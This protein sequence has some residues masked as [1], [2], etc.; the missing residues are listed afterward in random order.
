MK[1]N[2]SQSN[3]KSEDTSLEDI[4]KCFRATYMQTEGDTELFDTDETIEA[5]SLWHKAEIAKLFEQIRS[6]VK[7]QPTWE[8]ST[9][10]EAEDL[11]EALNR[12]EKKQ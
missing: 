3:S 4:R 5:I 2:S 12:L 7:S 9:M 11:L 6:E 1:N 8:S 10:I